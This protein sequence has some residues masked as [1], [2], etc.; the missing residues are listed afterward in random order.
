MPHLRV[1]GLQMCTLYPAF[2]WAPGSQGQSGQLIERA[3]APT[4]ASPT[5]SISILQM[6][7]TRLGKVR[8]LTQMSRL[9]LLNSTSG[10]FLAA[11]M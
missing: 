8:H 7:K 11:T 3:L 9:K 10:A 5:S 1:L 2:A 6:E 4:A